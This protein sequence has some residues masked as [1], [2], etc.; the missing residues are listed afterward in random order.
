MVL[1]IYGEYIK[2]YSPSFDDKSLEII[3]LQ[4]ATKN[5]INYTPR[6]LENVIKS[7][8]IECKSDTIYLEALLKTKNSIGVLVAENKSMIIIG[9]HKAF[10]KNFLYEYLDSIN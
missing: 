1:N 9:K 4:D 5:D 7:Y 3:K 10:D 8:I 2:E 6:I